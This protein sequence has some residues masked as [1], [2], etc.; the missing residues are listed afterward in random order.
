LDTQNPYRSPQTEVPGQVYLQSKIFYGTTLAWFVDRYAFFVPE[1]QEAVPQA[2]AFYEASG[3]RLIGRDPLTF[4]RGSWWSTLLGPERRARQRIVV[5]ISAEEHRVSLD[6]HI[7]MVLPTRIYYSSQK[8][9][10][11]LAT[12]LGAVH[13][14]TLR[15]EES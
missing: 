5:H 15:A 10:M 12:D 9:A 8:E 6:Y 2:I 14:E 4:W 11:R 13:P 1:I 3:A 7:N